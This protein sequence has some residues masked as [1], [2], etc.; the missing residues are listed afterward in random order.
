MKSF[1][2]SNFSR[3]LGIAGKVLIVNNNAHGK[4][5][6]A[7]TLNQAG[8]T[9]MVPIHNQ[10]VAVSKPVLLLP[11]TVGKINPKIQPQPTH[12]NTNTVRMIVAQ[13]N[14]GIQQIRPVP[15]A[16]LNQQMQSLAPVSLS[17]FQNIRP[18]SAHPLSLIH[19]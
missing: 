8:A 9:N 4:S 15:G 7:I 6:Q 14:T 5:P 10:G 1:N 19:I 16:V 18:K 13:N 2:A 11:N 12:L 3:C 17:N